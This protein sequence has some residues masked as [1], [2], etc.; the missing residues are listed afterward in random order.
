MLEFIGTVYTMTNGSV[1]LY[2]DV[3][4]VSATKVDL[5]GVFVSGVP[6]D[7]EGKQEKDASLRELSSN[8]TAIWPRDSFSEK[9][10]R[11][12]ERS[13]NNLKKV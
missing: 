7:Q 13:N 2:N 4:V 3:Y 11:L 1:N 8:E 10:E 6:G 5:I 12:S 9:L